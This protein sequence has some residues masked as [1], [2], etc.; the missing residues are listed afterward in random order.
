MDEIRGK[1]RYSTPPPEQ[2]Y[3]DGTDIEEKEKKSIVMSDLLSIILSCN[4]TRAFSYEFSPNQSYSVYWEFNQTTT[5]HDL[6]HSSE[7]STRANIVQFAM[8][9]LAYLSNKLAEIPEGAT[10]VLHNSLIFST[11]EHAN[12]AYHNYNDHPL[13]YVGKAGGNLAGNY[14]YQGQNK[15]NAADALFTAL[16]AVE[17][18]IDQLGQAPG[19]DSRGYGTPDRRTNTVISEVLK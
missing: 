16:K 14:W 7:I 6:S 4:L 10:N 18:P 19:K 9:N 3:G 2:S 11:S 12:A 13:L 17:V 5:H 1:V 15:S 8:K